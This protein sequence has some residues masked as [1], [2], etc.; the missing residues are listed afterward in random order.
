MNSYEVVGLMYT[1][2]CPL[3]CQDCITESSPTAKGKMDFE[4]ARA[5]LPAIRSVSPTVC[6]TG[7]EPLLFYPEILELTRE[8]KA[9][10]L[11]VSLVS[12]AGWVRSEKLARARIQ[13]LAAAGLSTICISWDR[14]HEEFSPRARA[15]LLARLAAEAG[16]EITL[17]SVIPAGEPPEGPRDA[18]KGIPIHFQSV[19]AVPLGRAAS[20]PDSHFCWEDEPPRGVCTVIQSPAIDHDGTV[21]ACCG[22]SLYSLRPSPLVLGN[23]HDEPLE[24]IFAR[25]SQDPILEVLEL[26][27]SYGFYLLLKDHPLGQGLLNQR[28]GRYTTI[29]EMCIDVTN[30]TDLVAAVKERLQDPDTQPLLAAARLWRQKKLLREAGSQRKIGEIRYKQAQQGG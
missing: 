17:R 14:Y 19:R 24:V 5:Y 27:G 25:A 15:V 7:G 21:Y 18:F 23:T 9:L 13:Q 11:Y 30:D 3:A 28:N 4:Q 20:L 10:G 29:C 26:L 22:P 6:F 12:G 2:T 8:A 1:K 16:L